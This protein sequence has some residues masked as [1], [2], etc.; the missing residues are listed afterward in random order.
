MVHLT[1]L[2]D[3]D[4]RMGAIWATSLSFNKIFEMFGEQKKLPSMKVSDHPLCMVS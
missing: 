4:L 1:L 2:V 3:V